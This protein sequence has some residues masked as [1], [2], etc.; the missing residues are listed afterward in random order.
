MKVSPNESLT[1]SAPALVAQALDKE[2]NGA[3]GSGSGSSNSTVVN[4]L[5]KVVRKK[6]N[7]PAPT[8]ESGSSGKRKA[9]D[10]EV[11]TSTEKRPKLDTP[12]SDEQ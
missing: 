1:V 5:T 6:K 12:G 3:S 10:S 7:A 11:E 2:L 4:D 8:T 9:D